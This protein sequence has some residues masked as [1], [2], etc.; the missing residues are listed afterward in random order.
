MKWLSKSRNLAMGVYDCLFVGVVIIIFTGCS[1]SSNNNASVSSP[2]KIPGSM[3]PSNSQQTQAL[4]DYAAQAQLALSTLSQATSN[5]SELSEITA[6][7]RKYAAFEALETEATDYSAV[8][9]LAKKN[10]VEPLRKRSE[11]VEKIG[12]RTTFW[13]DTQDL[14]GTECGYSLS[15]VQDSSSS[16]VPEQGFISSTGKTLQLDLT[17]VKEKLSQNDIY[18]IRSIFGEK[19]YWLAKGD[20]SN[21]SKKGVVQSLA[22]I[23]SSLTLINGI[24]VTFE[25]AKTEDTMESYLDDSHSRITGTRTTAFLAHMPVGELAYEKTIT[26]L[27]NGKTT[28]RLMINGEVVFE[29]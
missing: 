27:D 3:K 13:S 17:R 2:V 15:Q 21:R 14:A 20:G 6:D 29:Q 24:Q 10:C 1:V 16:R 12:E 25:Y 9:Q 8:L 18:Q 19:K 26:Y 7:I 4:I 22:T 28:I 11:R 5:L 23:N